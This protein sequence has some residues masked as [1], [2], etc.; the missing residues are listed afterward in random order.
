MMFSA[1]L[2]GYA[3]DCFNHP[4]PFLNRSTSHIFQLLAVPSVQTRRFQ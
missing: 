4:F 2:S 3:E 1:A